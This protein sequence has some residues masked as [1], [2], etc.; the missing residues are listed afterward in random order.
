MPVESTEMCVFVCFKRTHISNST[1]YQIYSANLCLASTEHWE[2]GALP[3]ESWWRG[4]S[5]LSECHLKV[6]VMVRTIPTP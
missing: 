6:A 5:H 4:T 2:A 1:S 3:A